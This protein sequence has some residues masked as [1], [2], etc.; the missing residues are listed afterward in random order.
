VA[1]NDDREWIRRWREAGP[2]LP[3]RLPVARAWITAAP[4]PPLPRC[5]AAVELRRIAAQHGG[6]VKIAPGFEEFA[7]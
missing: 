5:L 4:S 6:A 2:T 3:D 1:W 7:P